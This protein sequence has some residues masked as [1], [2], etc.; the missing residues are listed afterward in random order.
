MGEILSSLCCAHNRFDLP[1]SRKYYTLKL[2][3]L[4][5]KND[6]GSADNIKSQ[7]A[8]FRFSKIRCYGM[9]FLPF[10]TFHSRFSRYKSKSASNLMSV[11]L[12]LFIVQNETR[13]YTVLKSEK[14]Q[15][16]YFCFCHFV[17]ILRLHSAFT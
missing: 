16:Y 2:D 4:E 6:E 11:K 15:D 14:S 3:K 10:T 7:K 5:K 13:I 9:Y 12:I 17:Y 1:Q 8:I